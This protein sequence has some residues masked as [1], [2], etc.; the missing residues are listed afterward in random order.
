MPDG[1]ILP[2]NT[3]VPE[4]IIRVP[5]DELPAHLAQLET[6]LSNG[7]M[8]EIVQGDLVIA[9]VRAREAN[10][11]VRPHAPDFMARM[12]ARLGR[13]RLWRLY[14]VDSGRSESVV[15]AIWTPVIS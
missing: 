15:L 12:R 13:S 5:V 8:I 1:Q 11:V 9:E 6:E 14:T 3:T 10:P 7:R 2:N 4:L